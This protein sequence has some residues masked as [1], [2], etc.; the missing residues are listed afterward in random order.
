MLIVVLTPIAL[1]MLIVYLESNSSTLLRCIH[2]SKLLRKCNNS[3][4][5]PNANKPTSAVKEWIAAQRGH[6]SQMRRRIAIARKLVSSFLRVSV[7]LRSNWAAQMSSVLAILSACQVTSAIREPVQTMLQLWLRSTL[8]ISNTNRAKS[9][10]LQTEIYNN[11]IDQLL[12][13]YIY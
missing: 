8:G 4:R 10:L 7:K 13:W 5:A 11:S 2:P 1:E 12:C 3:S 6:A 9:Y